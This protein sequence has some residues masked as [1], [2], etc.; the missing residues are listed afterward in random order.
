MRRHDETRFTW[1]LVGLAIRLA[2][3]LGLHR[4]GTVFG[5]S[6]FDTEMRR[7]LWWSL[8]VLDLRAA[9]DFGTDPTILEQTYDTA[10]PLNINDEDITPGMTEFPPSRVGCSEMTFCL[11]RYEV[12]SAIRHLDYV[13]P[14]QG[15]CHE[16]AATL[17]LQQKEKLIEATN[18]RLE[19]RYLQY[20]D[21][22]IPLHWVTA[23]VGRLV[24]AK[25]WLMIYHPFQRP[26]STMELSPSV[27][28]RLFVTSI[29]VL[30]YARLL[31]TEQS[32]AKWGWMFRTYV[33][34]HPIA[35][36]LAELC[37]STRG[38][39][40]DRAW[41]AINGVFDSWGERV[42]AS[43]RG[44]LW[45][46]LRQLMI[47]AKRAREATLAETNPTSDGNALAGGP[48]P[49]TT[50][51]AATASGIDRNNKGSEIDE[52]DPLAILDNYPGL[53]PTAPS[54]TTA[55][56]T[57]EEGGFPLAET[58]PSMNW[59]EW[60][61]FLR[62]YQM[63]QQRLQLQQQQQHEYMHL[64]TSDFSFGPAASFYPLNGLEVGDLDGIDAGDGPAASGLPPV[65]GGIS[66]TGTG[67]DPFPLTT[68]DPAVMVAA[69][70]NGTQLQ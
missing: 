33:Q 6:P 4:D 7:R 19:E 22:T 39:V 35:Y 5:L 13:P 2:R 50:K 70:S 67:L 43:K 52:E 65:D 64:D 37:V 23:T 16:I 21:M 42:R 1:T 57:N 14:G 40:V 11:L 59:T 51:T 30:E 45:G 56:T 46:P 63:Q 3:A 15:T 17:S 24:M 27:R 31:E 69:G 58:S 9:E 62:E 29:E 26:G 20:C 41:N 34:W 36:L 47:K 28:H 8:C 49:T 68:V 25:L 44:M 54:Q 12:A 18:K 48:T 10:M 55:T 60:N 53:N 66:A 38:E 61:S 32:T